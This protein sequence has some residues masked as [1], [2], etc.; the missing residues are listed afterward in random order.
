M[1]GIADDDQR[2]R[3][4][5][6]VLK[7]RVFTQ[8][9]EQIIKPGMQVADDYRRYM[10]RQLEDATGIAEGVPGMAGFLPEK[11]IYLFQGCGCLGCRQG[12]KWSSENFQDPHQGGPAPQHKSGNLLFF[13]GK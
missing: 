3:A 10:V 2:S 6:H 5:L 7:E 8:D 12:L 1:Y 4:F 13:A 9:R 11:D